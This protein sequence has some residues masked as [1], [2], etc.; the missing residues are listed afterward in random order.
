MTTQFDWLSYLDVA[1]HLLAQAGPAIRA[2]AAFGPKQGFYRSTISRAYY[3]V[4]CHTRD[5]LQ[6]FRDTLFSSR[7][8]VHQ[9]VI[10]TLLHD[11]RPEVVALGESLDELRKE[12]GRADYRTRLRFGA[13]RVRSA[14]STAR[15]IRDG[16]TASFP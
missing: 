11:S 7:G 1:E 10:D 3:G 15:E 16:I 5:T 9:Q 8:D 2:A 14:L 13:N 6:P 12:R 4:L